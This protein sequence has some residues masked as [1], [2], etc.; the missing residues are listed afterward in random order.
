[1]LSCFVDFTQQLLL[2]L[3]LLWG[4]LKKLFPVASFHQ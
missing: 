4:P 3:L 1:L 2:L